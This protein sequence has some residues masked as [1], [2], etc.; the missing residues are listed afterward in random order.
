MKHGDYYLKVHQFRNRE[1]V[2]VGFTVEIDCDGELYQIEYPEAVRQDQRLLVATISN[3]LDKGLEVKTQLPA[4]TRKRTVWGL[5]TQEFHRVNLICFSPN[6]WDTK[7]GNQHYFFML[8]GCR[9]EGQARGFYNEFLRSDL[10]KHRKVIEMIG[11]RMRTEED[12]DQLSGLGFSVSQ[13]GE[14]IVRVKGAMTRT[15]RVVI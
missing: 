6:Y 14:L 13:N 11:A 8:D 7:L 12:K 4:K 15:L 5:D 2:D 9:N 10:S 3:S 1:A